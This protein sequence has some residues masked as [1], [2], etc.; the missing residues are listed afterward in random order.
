MGGLV[1]MSCAYELRVRA[2]D[3]PYIP[4]SYVWVPPPLTTS[5]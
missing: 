1:V 4:I 3:P 2:P 5:L